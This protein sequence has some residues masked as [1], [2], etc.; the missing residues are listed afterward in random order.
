MLLVPLSAFNGFSQEFRANL[1]R[2]VACAGDRRIRVS[3]ED[4]ECH[5]IVGQ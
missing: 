1:A 4:G 5:A 3:R 2:I